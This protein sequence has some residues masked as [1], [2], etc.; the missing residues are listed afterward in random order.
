MRTVKLSLLVVVPIRNIKQRLQ[1]S[2]RSFR[3]RSSRLQEDEV[4]SARCIATP[5]LVVEGDTKLK[6]EKTKGEQTTEARAEASSCYRLLIFV[7]Y[8]PRLRELELLYSVHSSPLLL[9]V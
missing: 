3:M 1:N 7:L 6:L 4:K 8:H 5:V 2:P 9:A